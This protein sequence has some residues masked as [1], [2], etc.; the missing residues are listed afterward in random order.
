M[1]GGTKVR[2]FIPVGMALE[3]KSGHY[4]VQMRWIAV[5]G[6]LVHKIHHSH[7]QICV[8][9]DRHA[10]GLVI[11]IKSICPKTDGAPEH[12]SA[13]LLCNNPVDFQARWPSRDGAL[14]IEMTNGPFL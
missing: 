10:Q 11:F 5:R 9:L 8:F 1:I 13:L 14:T 7:R 6:S 3:P 12:E 4:S 2:Q